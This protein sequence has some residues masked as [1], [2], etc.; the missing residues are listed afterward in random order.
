MSYDNGGMSE[1]DIRNMEY[2]HAESNRKLVQELNERVI[3]LE[4]AIRAHR[5]APRGLSW[6]PEVDAR[7]H[8]LVR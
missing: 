8:R 5:N 3:K 2:S 4:L 7:L 6:S 1:Q